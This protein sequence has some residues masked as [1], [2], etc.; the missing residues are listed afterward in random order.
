MC[1]FPEK[2]VF[3]F[4]FRVYICHNSA[5][6]PFCLCSCSVQFVIVTPV[7]MVAVN[8]LSEFELY[9]LYPGVYAALE[10]TSVRIVLWKTFDLRMYIFSMYN[11]FFNLVLFS[12]LHNKDWHTLHLS[13][14]LPLHSRS[15][16][17]KNYVGFLAVH[18]VFGT[19]VYVCA[20][21]CP[22]FMEYCL[23]FCSWHFLHFY[24]CNS[25]DSSVGEKKEGFWHHCPV[26]SSGFVGIYPLER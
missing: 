15:N 7:N 3:Q 25:W 1:Y 11:F 16:W 13:L 24:Q 26:G 21:S 22:S 14:W 8:C 2:P 10:N 5:F 9:T 18:M 19:W 4:V 12:Y 23:D 17:V 20:C 6:F